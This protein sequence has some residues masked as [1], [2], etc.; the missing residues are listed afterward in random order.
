MPFGLAPK[1]CLGW[2]F[3]LIEVKTIIYYL[4]T[5][6]NFETCEDTQIPLKLAKIPVGLETEK[7]IWLKLTP[8]LS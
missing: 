7:G 4:L 8:K 5:N 1:D 3:G 2:R 6:F